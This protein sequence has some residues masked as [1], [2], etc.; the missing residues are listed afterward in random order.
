VSTSLSLWHDWSLLLLLL[1]LLLGHIK[2]EMEAVW[3]CFGQIIYPAP[4]QSKQQTAPVG[5][6]PTNYTLYRSKWDRNLFSLY[7]TTTSTN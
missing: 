7:S 6:N 2:W 4:K 5:K 1:F 3:K